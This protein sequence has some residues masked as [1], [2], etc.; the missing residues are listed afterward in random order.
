[1]V[2]ILVGG[3]PDRDND[4]TLSEDYIIASYFSWLANLVAAHLVKPFIFPS[5][6]SKEYFLSKESPRISILILFYL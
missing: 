6:F 5:K 3:E 2:F 1:M 4:R